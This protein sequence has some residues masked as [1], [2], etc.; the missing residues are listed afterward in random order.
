MLSFL[1][2]ITGP[3]NYTH[4]M[5][6]TSKD[7]VTV[8]RRT[9]KY[10]KIEGRDIVTSHTQEAPNGLYVA[11]ETS[12]RLLILRGYRNKTKAHIQEFKLDEWRQLFPSGQPADIRRFLI[13][14]NENIQALDQAAWG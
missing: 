12:H 8:I 13:H 10:E 4:I 3:L 6:Q 2:N 7:F 1:R 14:Y 11:V 5:G 9:L